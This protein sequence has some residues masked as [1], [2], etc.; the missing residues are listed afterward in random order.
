MS[1]VPPTTPSS[2]PGGK[3]PAE[4]APSFN[5]T[6][7]PPPPPAKA[8]GLRSFAPSKKTYNQTAD[9]MMHPG[10][11]PDVHSRIRSLRS[12]SWPGARV[13]HS[14]PV[15]VGGMQREMTVGFAAGVPSILATNG[16]DFTI[17]L[18]YGV[19]A[20]PQAS[21]AQPFELLTDDQHRLLEEAVNNL[22][23]LH[24]NWAQPG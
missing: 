9:R 18:S 13:T 19:A 16:A 2:S 8:G 15:T 10:A 3:T 21:Q 1:R 20:I 17:G 23:A 14:W 6:K 11:P 12:A 22:E 24:R 5:M 7:T 4:E